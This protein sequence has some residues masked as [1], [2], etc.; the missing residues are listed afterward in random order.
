MKPKRMLIAGWPAVGVVLASVWSCDG[1]H[2]QGQDTTVGEFGDGIT[3]TGI[4][5]GFAFTVAVGV[6]ASSSF[7]FATADGSAEF[8][9]GRQLSAPP[10]SIQ[11][12]HV[13]RDGRVFTVVQAEGETRIVE[14]VG[15]GVLIEVVSRSLDTE[16]LLDIAESVTYDP[17]RDP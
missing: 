16:A 14:D 4:P 13:T 15:N 8:S 12:R 6:G 5:D 7:M 10:M 11:G 1:A 9:V 17:A 3:I 2:D